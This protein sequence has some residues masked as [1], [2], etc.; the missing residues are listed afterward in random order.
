MSRKAP[1][2]PLG[3][4]LEELE[5][6]ELVG[7]LLLLLLEDAMVRV[8]LAS[9]R[10]QQDPEAFAPL[11]RV[12]FTG[13]SQPD[14]AC[15]PPFLGLSARASSPPSCGVGGR[16]SRPCGGR[17]R[18]PHRWPS[19]NGSPLDVCR[20]MLAACDALAQHPRRSSCWET[21]N[22]AGTMVVQDHGLLRQRWP[23]A[24]RCDLCGKRMRGLFYQVSHAR[25]PS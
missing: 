3:E 16:R 14:G 11:Q 2:P 4:L 25:S 22:P 9:Y 18:H 20:S 8:H 7:V 10:R 6:E 5:S 24:A 23:E 1:T 12:Q 15:E 17:A 13:L 19:E 21:R